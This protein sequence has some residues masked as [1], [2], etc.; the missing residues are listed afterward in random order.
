MPGNPP[1]HLY[2]KPNRKTHPNACTVL[3][4]SG[5]SRSFRPTATHP[6]ANQ[7]NRYMHPSRVNR[8]GNGAGAA[9]GTT[10][11]PLVRRRNGSRQHQRDSGQASDQRLHRV[12]KSVNGR[13]V[14][15]R[16]SSWWGRDPQH[17]TLL[18]DLTVCTR[19]AVGGTGGPAPNSQELPG[20]PEYDTRCYPT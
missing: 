6:R 18:S 14:Y 8:L 19:D 16:V 5:T 15:S 2:P 17:P 3:R 1:P 7:R 11:D 13:T 4:R 10:A 12:L 9:Q 20:Q